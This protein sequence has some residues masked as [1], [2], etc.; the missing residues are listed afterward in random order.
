MLTCRKCDGHSGG[1]SVPSVRIE[2]LSPGPESAVL[3]EMTTSK[4]QGR[5]ENQCLFVFFARA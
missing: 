1:G 3:A 4:G 5:M 2:L